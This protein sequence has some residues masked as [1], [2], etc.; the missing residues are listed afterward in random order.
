MEYEFTPTLANRTTRYVLEGPMLRHLS[1]DGVQVWACNL[2]HVTEAHYAV[3]GVR[4]MVNRDIDLKVAGRWHRISCVV[5]DTFDSEFEK[6]N[7]FKALSHDIYVKLAALQPEFILRIGPRRGTQ[8]VLFTVGVL[9]VVGAGCIAL[10][11]ALAGVPMESV[12]VGAPGLLAMVAIGGYYM[13]RN[14]PG[15]GVTHVP[16]ADF[17]PF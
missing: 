10:V 9:T 11:I 1:A 7:G 14:R 2:A 6:P 13:W 8:I 16:V 5:V 3:L 17:A 15:A 12:M 4:D